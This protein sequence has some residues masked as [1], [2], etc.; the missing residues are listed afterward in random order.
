MK[1]YDLLLSGQ[2]DGEKLK[3]AIQIRE[4]SIS[5]SLAGEVALVFVNAIEYLLT[6]ED[7]LPQGTTR[8]YDSEGKDL[9]LF[10]RHFSNISSVNLRIL[11][12]HFGKGNLKTWKQSIS[13]L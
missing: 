7:K 6:T 1:K 3:V 2:L 9:N 11:P 5:Q 13:L 4:A 12:C 8:A 10:A